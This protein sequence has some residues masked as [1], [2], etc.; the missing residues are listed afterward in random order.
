MAILTIYLLALTIEIVN[1][2]YKYGPIRNPNACHGIVHLFYYQEIV[3]II[4][5]F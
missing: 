5:T 3:F 1:A 4:S 2:E